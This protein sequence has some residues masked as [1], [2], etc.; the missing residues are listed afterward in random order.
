MTAR[1]IARSFWLAGLLAVPAFLAFPAF[2]PS[3]AFAQV[4]AET[5]A[6]LRSIFVARDFDAR[7]FQ[8]TWL[9]DGSGIHDP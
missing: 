6:R 5:E 1:R 4:P 8:A 2:P 9:P 7:S 3:P